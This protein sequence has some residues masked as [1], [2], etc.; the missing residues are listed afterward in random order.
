MRSACECGQTGDGAKGLRTVLKKL[1]RGPDRSLHL[2]AP[3]PLPLA[4][5]KQKDFRRPAPKGATHLL[6]AFSAS[7]RSL[8]LG[9]RKTSHCSMFAGAVVTAL[10]LRDQAARMDIAHLLIAALADKPL[11]LV[12]GT[13]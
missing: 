9:S 4:F 6:N 8:S 13:N 10:A 7:V 12:V 3:P 5:S 2:R 11:P 1:A